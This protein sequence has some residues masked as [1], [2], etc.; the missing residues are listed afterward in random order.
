MFDR[1][2]ESFEKLISEFSWRRLVFSIALLLIIVVVL[3]GFESYTGYGRLSR[4]ERAAALLNSIQALQ[5]NPTIQ[6]DANLSATLGALKH[7]LRNFTERRVEVLTLGVEWLK[8]LA[9]AAPWLLFSLL[10]LPAIRAGNR[11]DL[12]G[13]IGALILAALFGAIGAWLPDFAYSWINYAGYPIASFA[14]V[15]VIVMWWQSR[16]R[17]LAH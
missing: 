7:D 12:H 2:F 16:K 15:I 6:Q 4:I 1:L 9:G 10:Y 17:A 5:S 11:S 13:L 3:W 14:A 8:A